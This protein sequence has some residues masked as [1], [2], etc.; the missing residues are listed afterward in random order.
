MICLCGLVS[1]CTTPQIEVRTEIVH[2]EI[3]DTL[4]QPVEVRTRPVTGLQGVAEILVDAKTA[5]TQ[6]NCQIAGMDA[7]V[8]QNRGQ[9][10]KDWSK[11]CPN[12][13]QTVVTKPTR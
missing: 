12:P 3:P 4:L 2:D 10:P 13:V 1:A 6:A 8:R 9:E 7:I 11:W 5:L